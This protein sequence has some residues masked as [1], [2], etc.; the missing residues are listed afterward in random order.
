M[1]PVTSHL[2]KEKLTMNGP[3]FTNSGIELVYDLSTDCFLLA[4]RRFIARR[5][6][7]KRMFNDNG[8]NFVGAT[9]VLHHKSIL[10]SMANWSIEG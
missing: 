9:K 2:P 7:P 1:F 6:R 5:G 10:N 3:P 4:F 8:T